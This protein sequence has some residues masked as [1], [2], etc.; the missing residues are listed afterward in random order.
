MY[1]EKAKT[2]T[3]FICFGVERLANAPKPALLL[4]FDCVSD[5]LV[6]IRLHGPGGSSEEGRG[7]IYQPPPRDLGFHLFLFPLYVQFVFSR[8]KQFLMYSILPA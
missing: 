1:F 5:L 8:P 3:L 6:F 4:L 2:T 7:R